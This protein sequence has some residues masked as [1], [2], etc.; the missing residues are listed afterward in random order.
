MLPSS[1]GSRSL[2][3]SASRKQF[4]WNS[5]AKFYSSDKPDLN[6]TEKHSQEEFNLLEKHF[7][8]VREDHKAK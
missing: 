5:F 3:G 4:D 7:L 6:D 2:F 8:S 1:S